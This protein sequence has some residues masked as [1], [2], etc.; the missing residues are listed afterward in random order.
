MDTIVCKYCQASGEVM[1]H[2][3]DGAESMSCP[4]CRGSGQMPVDE[5]GRADFKRILGPMIGP[6]EFSQTMGIKMAED[7]FDGHSKG[8]PGNVQASHPVRFN[9]NVKK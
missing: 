5:N 1:I 4:M 7:R 8:N 3:E 6:R 9:R 2:S